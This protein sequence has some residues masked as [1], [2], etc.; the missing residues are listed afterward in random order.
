MLVRF[1]SIS[2]MISNNIYLWCLL[3]P[4]MGRQ[5]FLALG[6][7]W[8]KVMTY[9]WKNGW[10]C[11]RKQNKLIAHVPMSKNR[12]FIL[13]IDTVVARCLN[14][15]LK[16]SIWLSHLWFG[17]VNLWSY[18]A[19]V[20]TWLCYVISLWSIA[21]IAHFWMLAWAVIWHRSLNAR[22]I[23]GNL[24]NFWIPSHLSFLK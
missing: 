3:C 6:N 10:L 5:T 18:L 9:K 23:N 16:D 4:K 13:N 22:V 20:Y 11:L 8:R 17:Y 21:M 19:Y 14:A 7:S 24:E 1:L 12:I 2:R 15:C